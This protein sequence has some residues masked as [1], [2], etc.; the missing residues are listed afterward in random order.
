MVSHR[1]PSGQEPARKKNRTFRFAAFC[2][3]SSLIHCAAALN[4]R[5]ANAFYIMPIAL[6]SHSDSPGQ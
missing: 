3:A 2:R 1:P 6:G 5:G 4:R